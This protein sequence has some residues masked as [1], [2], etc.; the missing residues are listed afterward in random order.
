MIENI[1]KHPI[2]YHEDDRAQRLQDVYKTGMSDAQINVSYINSTEHSVGWHCHTRQTEYWVVVKGA[3]KIGLA[4]PDVQ[5]DDGKST[6]NKA[7]EVARGA[8]VEFEYLSDKNMQ[9]LEIPPNVFHGYKALT[10]GTILMYYI[11]EKYEKVSRH[12]DKRVP[13]GY[14]GE[15]WSTPSK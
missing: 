3:L 10:P 6:D 2:Q 7:G 4:K 13:I 9:A 8:H 11:T 14:F 1:K 15:D 5:G 12:D